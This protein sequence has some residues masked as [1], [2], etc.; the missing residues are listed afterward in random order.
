MSDPNE[1][2]ASRSG[3]ETRQ[4]D[5]HSRPLP[6]DLGPYEKLTDDFC[7]L[8]PKCGGCTKGHVHCRKCECSKDALSKLLKTC[9]LCKAELPATPEYFFRTDALEQPWKQVYALDVKHLS[10]PDINGCSC[11]FHAVLRSALEQREKQ[12]RHEVVTKINKLLVIQSNVDLERWEQLKEHINN[13]DQ[14]ERGIESATIMRFRKMLDRIGI[15]GYY[16]EMMKE[17]GDE[18]Q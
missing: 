6:N 13:L 8:C 1:L 11:E 18:P 17:F 7:A 9:P 14:R 2:L 16:N 12:T 4:P 15:H 5:Q 10:E 3:G